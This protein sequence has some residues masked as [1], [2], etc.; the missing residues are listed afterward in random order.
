MQIYLWI[1]DA[2]DKAAYTFWKTLTGELF[3]EVIVESK[4][5]CSRLIKAIQDL[6]DTD[7]YYI[8]AYDHSFD[9]EQVVRELIHLKRACRIHRNIF[10]LDMISFEYLLLEFEKLIQWIYA[11]DD[12]FRKSR[13]QLI[14]LREELLA[15]VGHHCDYKE[16]KGI[17]DYI[18]A[19]DEYNIERLASKILFDL[20]R[21]TGFEVSKG[22][23]GICWRSSCCG[24]HERQEDDMC[25]LD[26]EHPG[27][28]EKMKEIFEHSRLKEEFARLGLGDIVC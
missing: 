7:N 9:N 23:L 4:R 28:G 15:A 21:N 1:E 25:G 12:G 27:L 22:A 24:F 8:I 16:I 17:R 13:K 14:G 19:A 6:K 20:T 2:P 5:N 3:P 18:K 11:E 10:E 26:K